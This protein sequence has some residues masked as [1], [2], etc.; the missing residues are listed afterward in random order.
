MESIRQ[1]AV[2]AGINLHNRGD[3][4]SKSDSQAV[5][6]SSA[7][8]RWVALAISFAIAGGSALTEFWLI[9]HA[10]MPGVSRAV[11]RV[12][13][14]EVTR[15][16]SVFLRGRDSSKHVLYIIIICLGPVEHC[17]AWIVLFAVARVVWPSDEATIRVKH[18]PDWIIAPRRLI[19]VELSLKI[20]RLPLL[21][22]PGLEIVLLIIR[23][24]ECLRV[25]IVEVVGYALTI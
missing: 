19:C 10:P 25:W 9:D 23:H 1:A 20:H 6:F 18:K 15:R 12:S 8:C 5:G 13:H 4:Y 21:D 7:D 16:D 14:L 2:R 17:H 24:D 3:I 11:G 22:S